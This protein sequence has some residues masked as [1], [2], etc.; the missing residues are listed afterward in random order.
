MSVSIVILTKNEEKNL[1]ECLNPLKWCDE[2]IVVDDNSTDKTVE[3]AKKNGA[4][5]FTRALNGD[6]AAQRNFGL[7]KAK[8]E[9]V[10][11][12][13][14][15][16]RV[17]PTLRAEI[18]KAIGENDSIYNGF[19]FKREDKIWGKALKFGETMNV[20]L[21]RLAKKGIGAWE[22]PVHEVW[23]IKGQIGIF[24]SPLLH[25]PHQTVSEFLE[26]INFYSTLRAEELYKAGKKSNLLEILFYAKAKF[27]QNYFLRRGFL[28]GMDGFTVA[29]IM[30]FHSFLVRS[31]LYLLGKR[32]TAWE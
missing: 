32:Q 9:W 4:E 10:F 11:F 23:N 12:V 21:L 18:T 29:L 8:G 1:E 24:Q 2:V 31:K 26:E 28:D 27:F 16:E 22:K 3:I 7:E 6:F 19:Y 25:Y 20:R 13:D 17:S 15:D 5:V 14:A 30:S